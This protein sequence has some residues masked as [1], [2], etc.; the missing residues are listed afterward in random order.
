MERVSH[1]P[2]GAERS[3]EDALALPP[4]RLGGPGG[5]SLPR[6]LV[7]GAGGFVGGFLL[8]HLRETFPDAPLFGATQPGFPVPQTPGVQWAECDITDAQS[9]SDFIK[10]TRPNYVY[11]LAGAASGAA[12]DRAM[13]FAVNVEGTRYICDAVNKHA[14]HARVLL[15]STGYV[16]GDC[17]RPAPEDKPLPPP[18]TVGLYAESK[19]DAELVAR[20]SGADVVVSRAFNH[21]GPGQ[22][23]AF[24]VPAFAAQIVQIERGELSQLCVGNVDAVRDFLDVRDVVRAYALLLTHGKRGEVYN[25]ASGHGV[26]VQSVLNELSVLARVPISIVTDAARLRPSDI[27][28]NVGDP[29]KLRALT[30]WQPRIPFAQT[31]SDTLD[32]WRERER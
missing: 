21:T 15:A 27:A 12:D 25:V 8:A 19:R 20:Q 6:I 23:I 31:L 18:E 11:H 22:T 2:Q 14:P 5:P 3:R 26:S 4:P 7:T 9:V 24:S 13:V 28:V 32:W 30:G 16:Y 29:S 10:D 1:G 17:P